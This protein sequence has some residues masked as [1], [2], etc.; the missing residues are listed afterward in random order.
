[1][2]VG[3]PTD[4]NSCDGIQTGTAKTLFDGAGFCNRIQYNGAVAVNRIDIILFDSSRSR[5]NGLG[6]SIEGFI[7]IKIEWLIWGYNRD[8]LSQASSSS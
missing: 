4:L 7:Y 8:G 1:M 6:M 2:V 5:W 3:I